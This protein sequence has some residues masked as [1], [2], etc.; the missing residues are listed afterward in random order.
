MTFKKKFVSLI[1]AI[2]FLVSILTGCSSSSSS[3]KF[4][5][6]VKNGLVVHYIDV[7][8]GDS[9]LVQYK[10]KNLLI[11]A[12]KKNA[13]SDVI[14]YLNKQG[15][16]KLDYV[17]ATHP[18]EDHIGGM[19]GVIGNFTIDKFFAPKKTANTKVF[20]DMINALRKKGLKINVAKA[21]VTLDLGNDINCEMLAPNNS[22][23]EDLNNYSAVIKITYNKTKFL[24][25]GDAETLSE[26]EILDNKL[27]VSCDVLK[28][29]HH[30]SSSSTSKNFLNEAS[31]KIA[32]ISCGK[33]NDYGH[34][35][36]VTLK[37]L[38]KKNIKVLR[39]DIQGNIVITSD[40]NEINIK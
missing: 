37:K 40:G 38:Q 7:G 13:E 32:I 16:K 10:N 25:M 20:K 1:L 3:T 36:K 12:G 8:Q 31:P 18:H 24:F 5:N 19:E 2:I 6:E 9:I 29:G 23:Y 35:H 33:G 22:S 28:V 27:D 30:G 4:T 39:T 11:D 26:N 17:V 14:N 15:V 34:P 21:G